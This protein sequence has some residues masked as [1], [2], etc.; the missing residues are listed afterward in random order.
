MVEPEGVPH[1]RTSVRGKIVIF[2]DCFSWR[3]QPHLRPRRCSKS[4]RG[5][6]PG[7]PVE[8]SGVVEPHAAFL[9]RKPHTQSCLMLRNRKSGYAGANVGHPSLH[10]S[11]SSVY[12]SVCVDYS[13]RL[14]A[15]NRDWS[16]L[17]A[18]PSSGIKA[19]PRQLLLLWREIVTSSPAMVANQSTTSSWLW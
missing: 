4:G 1:V 15:T 10:P 16:S 12:L 13:R 18:V 7:F 9:K 2:F 5:A 6:S 3:Q 14:A 8:V 17:K 11:T 19:V